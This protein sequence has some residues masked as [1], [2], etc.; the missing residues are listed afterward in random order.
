M[1]SPQFIDV[2]RFFFYFIRIKAAIKD[3]LKYAQPSHRLI[4]QLKTNSLQPEFASV[5]SPSVQSNNNRGLFGAFTPSSTP[6]PMT[7]YSQGSRSTSTASPPP[8][9]TFSQAAPAPLPDYSQSSKSSAFTFGQAT[10]DYSQRS[11]S[12]STAYHPSVFTLGQVSTP[13]S[14]SQG[15]GQGHRGA[16]PPIASS[17]LFGPASMQTTSPEVSTSKSTTGQFGQ[18]DFGASSAP[19][20]FGSSTAPGK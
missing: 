3:I 18:H 12:T 10:P 5:L 20:I 8:V 7:D 19:Y 15:Q 1:K 4:E 2:I 9:L 13:H 11:R 17:T 6:K 16:A 14:L